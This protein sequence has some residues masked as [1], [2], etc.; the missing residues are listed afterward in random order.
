M[1]VVIGLSLGRGP[2]IQSSHRSPIDQS[3]LR[4]VTKQPLPT[5]GAREDCG[6]AS[7]HQISR[8]YSHQTRQLNQMICGSLHPLEPKNLYFIDWRIPLCDNA[9]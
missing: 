3:S 7:H 4:G 1:I 8:S 2:S 6:A 5:I 9:P